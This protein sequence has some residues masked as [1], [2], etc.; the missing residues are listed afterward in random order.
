VAMIKYGAEGALEMCGR[1]A[2]LG[3]YLRFKFLEAPSLDN[4]IK[5]T[6]REHFG[7]LI[8]GRS[9]ER[10]G[11]GADG[12]CVFDQLP[13][14]HHCIYVDKECLDSV[15]KHGGWRRQTSVS[16]ARTAWQNGLGQAAWGPQPPARSQTLADV[17]SKL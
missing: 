9:V 16:L 11:T 13:R 7:Y 5:D 8:Q 14:Y 12:L 2:H 17:I 10:D 3:P 1:A 4:S 15:R 6:I